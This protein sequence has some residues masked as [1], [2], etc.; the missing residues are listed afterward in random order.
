MK[1]SYENKIN[2]KLMLLQYNIE[3]KHEGY[4]YI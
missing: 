3:N 1:I 2:S 4:I